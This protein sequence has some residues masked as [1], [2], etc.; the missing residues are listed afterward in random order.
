MNDELRL[1]L[2]AQFWTS[3]VAAQVG[4]AHHPGTTRDAAPRRSRNSILEEADAY[5]AEFDDRF[6][7]KQD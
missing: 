6:H 3:L 1:M 7:V 2:R 5:L 4:F